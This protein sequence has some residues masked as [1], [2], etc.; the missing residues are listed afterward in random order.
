MLALVI[1]V[2]GAWDIVLANRWLAATGPGRVSLPMI[3]VDEGP[4]APAMEGRLRQDRLDP[5]VDDSTGLGRDPADEWVYRQIVRIAGNWNLYETPSPWVAWRS[6]GVP[7]EPTGVEPA[8]FEAPADLTVAQGFYS[9]VG[10]AAEEHPM[11][12]DFPRVWLVPQPRYYESVDLLRRDLTGASALSAQKK[13]PRAVDLGGEVCLQRVLPEWSK[14]GSVQSK[15]GKPQVTIVDNG[16]A[17]RVITLSK[18]E[19]DGFVVVSERYD[20]GWSAHAESGGTAEPRPVLRANGILMAVPVKAGDSTITLRYANRWFTWGMWISAVS[21]LN[22]LLLLALSAVRPRPAIEPEAPAPEPEPTPPADDEPLLVAR[23]PNEPQ[24]DAVPLVEPDEPIVSEPPQEGPKS[25]VALPDV[26]VIEEAP[27]EEPIE[28][29]PMDEKL[30]EPKPE[31]PAAEAAEPD[32]PIEIEDAL[33]G[34]ESED[35]SSSK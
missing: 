15:F 6:P 1:W 7:V 28:F 33:F 22:V 32:L 19:A 16:P 31:A 17:E 8:S 9:R 24:L 4:R 35:E 12:R 11:A 26:P 29:I 3:A 10:R 13:G 2:V 30:D 23:H 25:E 5:G 14:H 21:V 18:L 34:D 20:P 27:A